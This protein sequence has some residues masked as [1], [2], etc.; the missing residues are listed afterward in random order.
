MNEK[1][2]EKVSYGESDGAAKMWFR[3]AILWFPFFATFGFIVAIKF[4]FP[5]F[6]ST[7]EWATFGRIRPSHVNGVLFGFLSSGLIGVMLWMVP[8]LCATPLY[9]PRLARATALLWNG[10]VLAGIVWIIQGGSQGREYA[11]LPWAIDVA[12]MFTLGLLI[13]IVFGTLFRRRERKLYVSL[14]YYA[15]TLLWFPVI[16]FIGN[17]MWHVPVGALNGT[18]DAIFNWYYGH[19]VLGLWFTTLGIPAWYYF[20]PKIIKRPLYSHLLSLIAFFSLAFFYT[21]VGAHHLLQ[22]PLP[23]WLRTIA[24][25]MSVLMIVPVIVFATNILLT[26]RGSW[27]QLIGNTPL[28]FVFAGFVMYIL[29]S[30]Q[31][32]F[33]SLRASNYFIHFSQWTPGHAHLALLGSFGFLAVGAAYYLIPQITGIRIYS[34]RLMRLSFWLAFV[35]FIL[36]FLSMTVAGLAANSNWWQHINPVETLPTLRDYFIWRAMAGGI[37]V[38]AAFIFAYNIIMTLVRAR[39]AHVEEV[40]E[41]LGKV[42]SFKPPSR[43]LRRSQERLS[44]PIVAAGGMAVFSVMTFMVVAMPYMFGPNEPSDRAHELTATESQGQALYKSLGCVYCH[45]QFVRTRDWAMGETSQSGDF[46][47]SI[48]NF[49]G[50]ERTG[51]N[52]G[53]IGDKRPTEWQI[54]HHSD[55][56][57]LSPSSI[58]PSFGFLSEE[59]HIALAA[60]LQQL[61]TLSTSSPSSPGFQPLV[62]DEYQDMMNPYSSLQT[63]VSQKYDPQTEQYSGDEALGQQWAAL[64]E[65]GKTLFVEKC[66]SCH[67]CS[68]N[69]QGPYASNIVTLPAN[70]HE[71]FTRYSQ[72]SDP[73]EIW[74]VSEGVP[75]TGMPP[76]GISQTEATLWKII[77]Y[78]SSFASGAIRTVSPV[79]PV[80]E[81]IKFATESGM[82][83]PISGTQ[84]QYTSGGSLYQLYCAQCHGQ[85]GQGDG[86]ASIASPGGY[87]RPQPFNLTDA[88]IAFQYYGEYYWFLEN[89]SPT[90]NM[91]PWVLALSPEEAYE[92]IFYIQGFSNANDYNSKWAPQYTDDFAKNLKR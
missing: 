15:G 41:S 34:R 47:Y 26:M 14:W 13:Y 89:G 8:R 76:W 43:F 66:L 50:T 81:A 71:R 42:E 38:V 79:V 55:P 2:E 27:R 45:S 51:P 32:S 90:T 31:G 86:P 68:G 37:V 21:G 78:E 61:G 36:F 5:D 19:N 25:V 48:P 10:A 80:Q 92:V 53:Q 11:E 70:I 84:E 20:I 44:L 18:R 9:R 22:A 60:Y 63:Q 7:Q 64:F 65:E 49:L 62:P 35:G 24:V 67:G 77:T 28:Q 52:L 33:Q 29:T 87:I 85:G 40:A 91:P 1:I 17:V 46:Y 83:P 30:F 39:H 88:G 54:Q 56:R 12:V 69:G 58:M 72:P 57:S 6:I 59:E 75:G 73:F 74:R 16:Y 23:E 3:F 4:F 82:T